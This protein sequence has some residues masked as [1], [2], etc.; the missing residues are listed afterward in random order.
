MAK[1][2]SVAENLTISALRGTLREDDEESEVSKELCTD[3]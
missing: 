3:S 2:V 1:V